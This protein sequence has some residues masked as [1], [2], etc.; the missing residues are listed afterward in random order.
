MSPDLLCADRVQVA[1]NGHTVKT[2][3]RD[4]FKKQ[5]TH[6]HKQLLLTVCRKTFLQE[7]LLNC[8]LIQCNVCV[9]PA[10]DLALGG[11]LVFCPGVSSS[12]TT[13]VMG[14]TV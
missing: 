3:H 6:M 2:P 9:V 12:T 7:G 14:P 8:V 10:K 13:F 11:G 4:S 1:V 5:P